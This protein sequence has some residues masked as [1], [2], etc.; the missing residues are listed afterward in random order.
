MS[1]SDVTGTLATLGGLAMAL[2]PLL[3]LRRAQNRGRSEDVSLTF[4]AVISV[5]AM[6][7]VAHGIVIREPPVIVANAVAV[8]AALATVSTIRRQRRSND[9][10]HRPPHTRST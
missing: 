10:S 6:V 5:G 1:L 3:Q 7:W 8:L 9:P 4:L 2:G